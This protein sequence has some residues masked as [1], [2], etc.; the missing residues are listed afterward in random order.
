MSDGHYTCIVKTLT[1]GSIDAAH[2]RAELVDGLNVLI[3]FHAVEYNTA[4]YWAKGEHQRNILTLIIS[5]LTGLKVSNAI[6]ECHSPNGNTRVQ[7][8]LVEIEP[9]DGTGVHSSTFLLQST[10]ELD[11]FDFRCAGDS[12]GRENG[13]EGVKPSNEA[14][15]SC[16]SVIQAPSTYRVFPSRSW[17][18]I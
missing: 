18:L 7:F 6:L 1:L 3:L 8:I 5:Q 2:V 15:V 10:D 17:P 9:P 16:P 11:G 13:S 4:A 12:S 14:G